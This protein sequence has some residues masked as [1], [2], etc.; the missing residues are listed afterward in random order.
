MNDNIL[1]PLFRLSP[2]FRIAQINADSPFAAHNKGGLLFI[3]D[4]WPGEIFTLWFPEFIG[5]FGL[6]L[7]SDVDWMKTQR[8]NF[9]ESKEYAWQSERTESYEYKAEI[10]PIREGLILTLTITNLTN[11]VFRDGWVNICLRCCHAPSFNDAELTRTFL[12]IEGEWMPLKH[13]ATLDHRKQHRLILSKEY[14]KNLLMNSGGIENVIVKQYPT[15]NLIA[16]TDVEGKRTVGV[17]S[18][19]CAGFVVNGM[20]DMRCI[21]SNPSLPYEIK[22]NETASTKCAILLMNK[23]LQEVVRF[24]KTLELYGL[25]K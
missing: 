14:S 15:H 25:K 18:E 3:L 5:A 2:R 17:Y 13:L 7:R 23:P 9:N 24:V 21:H 6:P 8:W 22:P 10:K 16:V 20:E 19:K 12:S 11:E 4:D 1:E